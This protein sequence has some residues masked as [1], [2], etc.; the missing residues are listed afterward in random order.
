MS[1][2]QTSVESASQEV[3]ADCDMMCYISNYMPSYTDLNLESFDWKT[4]CAI[5]A[6]GVCM[7]VVLF[8]TGMMIRK[9]FKNRRQQNDGRQYKRPV[10]VPP[11]SNNNAPSRGSPAASGGGGIIKMCYRF[12]LKMCISALYVVCQVIG[13]L[14]LKI[15]GLR[16]RLIKMY[17]HC[18]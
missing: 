5:G 13:W 4:M 12:G 1:V 17:D 8:V 15:G 14:L 18:M 11:P 10:F 9:L 3:V 7:L 6:A 2:H 16:A